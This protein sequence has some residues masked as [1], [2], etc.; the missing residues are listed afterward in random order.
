MMPALTQ[1]EFEANKQAQLERQNRQLM[2]I[3]LD[4]H[5]PV[6][7]DGHT[8]ENVPFLRSHI[9]PLHC[10]YEHSPLADNDAAAY[11]RIRPHCGWCRTNPTR[12]KKHRRK[13][14]RLQTY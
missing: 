12:R 10:M 9:D 6:K 13:R 1:A 7:Q 4:S 5:Q 11:M 2:D 14:G 3:I 8:I